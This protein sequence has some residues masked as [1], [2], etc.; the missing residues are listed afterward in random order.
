MINQSQDQVTLGHKAYRI[1]LISLYAML[2]I[3]FEY[4]FRDS[5]KNISKKYFF[6]DDVSE[7]LYVTNANVYDNGGKYFLL[8]LILNYTNVYSALFFIFINVIGSYISSIG[9][10]FTIE[11]RPYM[12]VNGHYPACFDIY[13]LNE[14]PSESLMTLFLSFATLYQAFIQKKN[15]KKRQIA[16]KA[17]GLIALVYISYIKLVQNMIY[18]NQII[19]G[20]TIGYIIYVFFFE[21]LEVKFSNFNQ[22]KCCFQHKGITVLII[23]NSFLLIQY[24]HYQVGFSDTRFIIEFPT[25]ERIN[26]LIANNYYI[27]IHLFELL[28]FYFGL[29]AEYIKIMKENE[30][31]FIRYNIR[32]RNRNGM[33][34]YNN[35]NNDISMCRLIVFFLV[36]FYI[37]SSPSQTIIQFNSLQ[38]VNGNSLFSFWTI[39]YSLPVFCHFH[40]GLVQFFGLKWIV[41]QFGLTNERLFTSS[42]GDA[43][44][45]KIFSSN[46]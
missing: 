37:S 42:L 26:I 29:L 43:E 40:Y 13:S 30:D 8:Y 11:P 16:C 32:E 33:E 28:G 41:R 27:S 36:Q 6:I 39:I 2:I 17:I 31:I 44:L 35:T 10:I 4:I 15:T 46:K 20:L 38:L 45:K 12:D 1:A 34:M 5:L 14:T 22:L 24:F 9:L 19:L 3:L 21:I 18:L 23:L 25:K 7:C